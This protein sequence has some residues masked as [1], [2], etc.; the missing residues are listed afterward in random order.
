M[1]DTVEKLGKSLIQYG[2]YNNRIYLM[3]LHPDD[4]DHIVGDLDRMARDMDFSKIF[5]KIPS[6]VKHR[7][8]EAEYRAEAFIPKFY[9]GEKT[10]LFMAKYLKEI[11]SIDTQHDRV[12][13][14]IKAAKS[15]MAKSTDVHLDSQYRFRI[16]EKRDIPAMVEVYKKVFETYPFPIHDPDYLAQTMD[17]NLIYFTI[18]KDAELVAISSSEMDKSG[19][20]V[21]MTDFATLPEMRGAGFASFLLCEMEAKMREMGIKTAYTIARALSF[22]MNITFAKQGYTYSGTLVNNTNIFGHL[23]SMNVWYKSL[24]DSSAV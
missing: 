11:R 6:H 3:K 5:I 18:W 16:A 23:E 14:V 24:A 19:E 9:N 13:Q 22:G 2:N 8:T 21:E 12:K 4:E 15:K 20:N 10:I 1:Y 17:Q 7:F